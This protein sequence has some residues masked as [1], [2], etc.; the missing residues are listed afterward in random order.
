ML[1]IV[2][3][4]ISWAGIAHS[5]KRQNMFAASGSK[6]SKGGGGLVARVGIVG[7]EDQ[8]K[9]KKERGHSALKEPDVTL[10]LLFPFFHTKL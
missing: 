10:L 1:H 6:K 4:G 3:I 9:K 5:S 2:R 7:V 8:K